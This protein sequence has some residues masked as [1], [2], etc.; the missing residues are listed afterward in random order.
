MKISYKSMSETFYLSNCSPQDR[1]FN[2]G[3]WNDLE[4]MVRSWAITS[5]KLFV[6]TA[7]VLTQNKGK[8]GSNGI[9]V[10]KQFYKVLYDSKKQKMIAF[11]IPNENTSKPLTYF[12]TT[13]DSLEKLTGIDFFPELSDSIES[14]L[15]SSGDLS[16]WS[17]NK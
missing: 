16:V 3:I 17:F 14:L 8:I 13:V 12:V 1:D 6:V 10:P 4:N 2:A 9:T 7:G 5:G 11:L 15:E